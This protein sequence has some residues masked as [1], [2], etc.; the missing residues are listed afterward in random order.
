MFKVVGSSSKRRT[1][2][3]SSGVGLETAGSC[4]KKW[5]RAGNE[6]GVG[7]E[8]VGSC[9]K[10]RG[11]AGNGGLVFQA[12]GSGLKR[13]ARVSSSAVGFEMVGSSSKQC[14]QAGNGGLVFQEVGS[15]WKRARGRVGN[16]GFVFQAAG[17]SWK[18]RV[19]VPSSGVGLETAGSRLKQWGRA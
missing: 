4:S 18:R 16:G 1:R 15:G 9:S 7:L 13:R 17:S 11:R 3:R 6:L 19:S 10:Q 12:V 5:G 2:V 8:T 14:G